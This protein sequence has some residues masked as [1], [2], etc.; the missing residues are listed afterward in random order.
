MLYGEVVLCFLEITKLQNQ[1][2]ESPNISGEMKTVK[3]QSYEFMQNLFIQCHVS[4]TYFILTGL[5]I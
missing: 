3:R 1:G 5:F 2:L 4:L